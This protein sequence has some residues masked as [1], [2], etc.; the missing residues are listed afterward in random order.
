MNHLKTS[1]L[2]LVYTMFILSQV[3]CSTVVNEHSSLAS[4]YS[5]VI[6]IRVQVGE[7]CGKYSSADLNSKQAC[8]EIAKLTEELKHIKP[9]LEQK[10]EAARALPKYRKNMIRFS[11]AGSTFLNWIPL[12]KSIER[13]SKI[14]RASRKNVCP[15]KD[16]YKDLVLALDSYEEVIIVPY[17]NRLDCNSSFLLEEQRR[18]LSKAIVEGDMNKIKKLV[19]E[20]A[21][22]LYVNDMAGRNQFLRRAASYGHIDVFK[23]F[24]NEETNIAEQGGIFEETSLMCASGNGHTDMVEFLLK[25]GARKTIDAKDSTFGGH[26]A[27]ML[28]AEGG[29]ISII[30]CLLQY[31][32]DIEAKDDYGRT[33]LIYAAQSSDADKVRVLLSH[34]ANIHAKDEFGDTAQQ[35][36]KSIGHKEAYQILSDY[37]NKEID[38]NKK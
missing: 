17:L 37:L 15:L 1:T 6:D 31:G 22:E 10:A 29:G 3:A 13:V 27:L 21:S 33:A 5:E 7:V 4:I 35:K 2:F 30:Q 25:N 26:T 12:H 38:S 16:E 14:R 28:A 18:L 8:L 11:V 19:K 9:Y 34:G 23:F 32:A 36:A 24:M 20:G